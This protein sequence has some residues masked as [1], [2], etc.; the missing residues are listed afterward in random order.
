MLEAGDKVNVYYDPITQTQL[1]GQA[2]LLEQVLPDHGDGL[3]MWMVEFDDAPDEVYQRT[4]RECG[5][6]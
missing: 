4:I 1:E 2:T 5:E 6:E 3:S